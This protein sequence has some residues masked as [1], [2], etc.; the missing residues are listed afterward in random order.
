M[1]SNHLVDTIKWV[2]FINT[3]DLTNQEKC[4]S[5]TRSLPAGVQALILSSTKK[6]GSKEVGSSDFICKG[7]HP[8]LEYH[9]YSCELFSSAGNRLVALPMNSIQSFYCSFNLLVL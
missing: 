8:Y 5:R 6:L 2:A 4:D 1:T 9:Y 7:E 3:E